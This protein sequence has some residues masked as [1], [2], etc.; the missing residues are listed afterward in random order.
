VQTEPAVQIEPPPVEDELA[1]RRRAAAS[2]RAV[3]LVEVTDGALVTDEDPAPGS[4]TEAS[5]KLRQAEEQLAAA[6]A[7]H[8]TS[9]FELADAEAAVEAAED[10]LNE[11][12]SRRIEARRDK[13]TAQRHLAEAR[14]RQ[15]ATVN[16]LA[17]ARRRLDAARQAADSDE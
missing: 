12:D 10:A 13:V 5:P 16:A 17:D 14:S 11:L 2:L 9:E 6:E 1:A 3:Q 8:W 15:R 4:E 7:A